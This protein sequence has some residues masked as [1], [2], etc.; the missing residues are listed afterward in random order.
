[1]AS[2]VSCFLWL[3]RSTY[4]QRLIVTAYNKVQIE[5]QNKGLHFPEHVDVGEHH[6]FYVWQEE[7]TSLSHPQLEDTKNQKRL[8]KTVL[9]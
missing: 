4:V 9:I 1:M 2:A 5:I 7:L 8:V 6:N 3:R